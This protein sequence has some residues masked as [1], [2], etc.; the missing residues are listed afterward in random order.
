ML[1]SEII[2]VYSQI[3]TKH[4]NA[5]CGQNVEYF[6]AK[7]GGT[8]SYHWALKGNY[9]PKLRKCSCSNL[10]IQS[11]YNY[12]SIKSVAWTP[13]SLWLSIASQRSVIVPICASRG[14]SVVGATQLHKVGVSALLTAGISGLH[15][16]NMLEKSSS[17]SCHTKQT[18][19]CMQM[20]QRNHW[21]PEKKC[22]L[23]RITKHYNLKIYK[24]FKK[25]CLSVRY[26]RTHTFTHTYTRRAQ[27]Q[28]IPNKYV[29]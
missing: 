25:Q 6:Y 17:V 16:G 19:W 28:I 21:K 5:L 3:H 14:L 13:L 15:V 1:Y 29:E 22:I 11:S 27:N 23:C 12:S 4:I 26:A 10:H 20:P 24:N 18:D 2:A 9:V 8:Y 7:P